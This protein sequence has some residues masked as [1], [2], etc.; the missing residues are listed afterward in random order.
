V[1]FTTPAVSVMT[2]HKSRKSYREF[3]TAIRVR[4]EADVYP[5]LLVFKDRIQMEPRVDSLRLVLQYFRGLDSK[6]YLS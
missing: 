4:R 5:Q 2:S 3:W 6:E 1:G